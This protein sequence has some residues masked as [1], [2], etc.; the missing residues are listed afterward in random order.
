M[1]SSGGGTGTPITP[2]T[3]TYAPDRSAPLLP[4]DEWRRIIGWNPWHFWGF[5]NDKISPTSN[6]NGV[7]KQYDWQGTDAAGRTNV[8]DAILTAEQKLKQFLG[9]A[10]APRDPVTGKPIPKQ[11]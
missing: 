1:P 9:F 3:S 10:P 6:C 7:V 11:P 2:A 8:V 4:L 5:S